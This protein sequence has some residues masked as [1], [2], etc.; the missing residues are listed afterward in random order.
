[1]SR[2]ATEA[3]VLQS[4]GVRDLAHDLL[5]DVD[6]LVETPLLLAA[7]RLGADGTHHRRAFD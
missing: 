6:K 7:D 1:M 4:L 2:G 3:R 5:P